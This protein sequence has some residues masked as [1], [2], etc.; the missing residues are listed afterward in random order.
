[1]TIEGGRSFSISLNPS[2]SDKRE[3]AFLK[4]GYQSSYTSENIILTEGNKADWPDIYRAGMEISS[5]KAGRTNRM[6]W[7]DT[8]SFLPG[9]M[10]WISPGDEHYQKVINFWDDPARFHV[11]KALVCVRGVE[12][13]YDAANYPPIIHPAARE[14]DYL[15]VKYVVLRNFPQSIPDRGVGVDPNI[16][17]R[18]V[19]LRYMRHMEKTETMGRTK[20]IWKFEAWELDRYIVASVDSLP[21]ND[22]TFYVQGDTNYPLLTLRADGWGKREDLIEEI[23]EDVIEYAPVRD[24]TV[25]SEEPE[26]CRGRSMSIGLKPSRDTELNLRNPNSIIQENNIEE[27]IRAG[28]T[29][30]AVRDTATNIY[31]RPNNLSDEQVRHATNLTGLTASIR[32]VPRVARPHGSAPT[33]APLPL[34]SAVIYFNHEWELIEEEEP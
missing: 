18:E 30:K 2:D 3:P 27:Y 7:E 29:V 24:A 34:K 6:W 11:N 26:V 10:L 15:A 33:V 9:S 13:I 23:E 5:G 8:D 22:V 12:E 19:I 28:K 21:T 16:I 4:S 32:L 20:Y 17:G 31:G 14:K 25:E 1:M